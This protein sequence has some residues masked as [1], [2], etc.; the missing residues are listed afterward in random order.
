M[1]LFPRR[2][3]DQWISKADL[4]Q[5]AVVAA[6]KFLGTLLSHKGRLRTCDKREKMKMLSSFPK[7]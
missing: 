6:L 4:A 5:G 7:V 1:M 2:I 3:R